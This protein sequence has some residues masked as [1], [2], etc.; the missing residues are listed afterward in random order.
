MADPQQAGGE[1]ADAVAAS[2][3]L[4]TTRSKGDEEVL[5]GSRRAGSFASPE[6]LEPILE[7]RTLLASCPDPVTSSRTSHALK[8]IQRSLQL[9]AP[10]ELA[11]SFNG[12]KDST[13]LLHLL[14][15]AV[16][17]HLQ[18]QQQQQASSSGGTAGL[19]NGLP[20]SSSSPNLPQLVGLGG[21]HSFVFSHPDD[22]AQVRDFLDAADKK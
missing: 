20:A 8:L 22:F 9:Y 1:G 11:F 12:G 19:T 2:A 15:T 7:A 4:G 10:H 13:V 18:Q 17:H 6:E 14:R 16:A 3:P 21:M 5:L